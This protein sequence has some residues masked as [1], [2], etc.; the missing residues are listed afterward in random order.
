MYRHQD[1]K[2]VISI[3]SYTAAGTNGNVYVDTLGYRALRWT[4]LKSTTDALTSMSFQ[5]SDTTVAADFKDIDG[6]ATANIT[7]TTTASVPFAMC[8]CDLR[9][10]KRYFKMA[11]AG[12]TAATVTAF[13]DLFNPIDAPTEGVGFGG[14]ATNVVVV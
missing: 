14:T 7:P 5:T 9:G 6:A 4:G 11:C 1:F 13:V 8:L 2:T 12:A 3:S 10:K